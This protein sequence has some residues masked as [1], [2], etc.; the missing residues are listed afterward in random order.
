MHVNKSSFVALLLALFS[1]QTFASAPNTC[2][3]EDYGLVFFNGVL[4]DKYEAQS[5]VLETRFALG[6]NN[7]YNSEKLTYVLA[8]NETEKGDGFVGALRDFAE[9][10][11]QRADEIDVRLSD[12][13]ELF[14]LVL[15]G[16]Q[17]SNIWDYLGDVLSSYLDLFAEVLTEQ[18]H[19]VINKMLGFLYDNQAELETS[20]EHKA[21]L[22]A[23]M[24]QGNKVVL[25]A[26]SQGNLFMNKAYEHVK[27]VKAYSSGAVKAVHVAPASPT[28]NGPY[29]LS[30][31]DAVINSLDVLTGR[32]LKANYVWPP[33]VLHTD[34]LGHNY[35]DVYLNAP[36]G[37]KSRVVTMIKSEL[38]S[39]SKP[40]MKDYLVELKLTPK[41]N[42]S[43][44]YTAVLGQTD[45]KNKLYR[46]GYTNYDPSNPPNN[47]ELADGVDYRGSLKLSSNQDLKPTPLNS[48]PLNGYEVLQCGDEK[49]RDWLKHGSYMLT[50]YFPFNSAKH[51]RLDGIPQPATEVEIT[52]R[53][54][55]KLNIKHALFP[56]NGGSTSNHYIA[57]VDMALLTVVTLDQSDYDAHDKLFKENK[58]TK[59][60]KLKLEEVRPICVPH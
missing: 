35:I 50:T 2:K 44:Y 30:S 18:R 11:E 28:L 3:V 13:W 38:L 8:Y 20:Q 5:N 53:F 21:L 51:L 42:F 47:Q 25:L 57:C 59:P 36:S 46:S 27:N 41:F 37:L 39:V 4:T 16:Q 23:L 49:E 54:D 56:G 9:T 15:S 12:R 26:H 58:L 34:P 24:W 1:V 14:W 32:G 55:E 10:F 29:I 31:G 19:D 22:D 40:E 6:I 7:S 48:K 43:G 33:A 45:Y 60:S 17:S 52:D